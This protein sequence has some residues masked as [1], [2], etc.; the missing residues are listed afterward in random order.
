MQPCQAQHGLKRSRKTHLVDV[1]WVG[2]S[3]HGLEFGNMHK[4]KL[5]NGDL[6]HT[7]MADMSWFRIH[8]E[9]ASAV[10]TFMCKGTCTWWSGPR[11]SQW[12]VLTTR[13]VLS[14]AKSYYYISRCWR[15]LTSV[16]TADACMHSRE[17]VFTIFTIQRAR[18]IQLTNFTPFTFLENPLFVV[19]V[20]GHRICKPPWWPTMNCVAESTSQ[21]LQHWQSKALS[22]AYSTP[23]LFW[24]FV[25][26]SAR[27]VRSPWYDCRR[28]TLTLAGWSN[29]VT[30]QVV[31]QHE[32]DMTII[33]SVKK[34]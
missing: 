24:S 15:R 29:T 7:I 18:R 6:D 5:M 14:A 8:A 11:S 17:C 9:V 1:L 13:H 25:Q 21:K 20:W 3:P 26:P 31:S 19:R 23:A 22:T 12:W 10:A 4:L 30:A 32:R 33:E 16:D 27:L 28:T 2:R 34:A